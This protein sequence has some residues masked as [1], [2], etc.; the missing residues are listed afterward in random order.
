MTPAMPPD[1]APLADLKILVVEDE[2]LLAMDLEMMLEDAGCQVVGPAHSLDD[3]VRL[4]KEAE[5]DAALLDLNLT[6]GRS[7]AVADA[8]VERGAPLIFLTGHTREQLP[9]RH[10][11]A[12]LLSKPFRADGLVEALSKLLGKTG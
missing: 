5:L 6:E 3:G 11:D 2:V 1:T 9:D 4:A 10:R 8:L 7:D 12:P